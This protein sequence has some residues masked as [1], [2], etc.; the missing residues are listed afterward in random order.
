MGRLKSKKGYLLSLDIGTEFVKALIFKIEEDVL[1]DEKKRKGIVL[2]FSRQRQALGNMLAGAVADIDGVALT[3][4]SAIEEA[5]RMARV[6]PSRAVIGVAGEFIKGS[7][8]AFSYQRQDPEREID[9]S[10]L[11]NVVQKAQ[12]KAYDKM[13][14]QLA[15][16]IC[17]SEIEIR[18]VNS[19]IT[20][21]KIDGHPVTNPLGF[22]GG[23]IFLSTFS[24]YAPLVHL[25]ALESIAQKLKLDL[26][27]VSADS[28][29]LTKTSGFNPTAGAIFIDI[30]GGT[31]DV[32]LVRQNRMEGIKSFSLAGQTFTKCLSRNL[33]LGFNEAE[34]IKVR[35]GYG[36][37]GRNVKRKIN[38]ILK[39]DMEI[40]LNGVELILEDF[41]QAEYFPPA[42]LLCGGGSLLPGIKNILKKEAISRQ[43]WEKF[44]FSQSPQIGFIQPG[45][46]ENIIDQT[47]S[48]N[49]PEDVTPLAL[50]SL[51][52]E[53]ATEE[54]QTLPP[55][56]R[57]MARIMHK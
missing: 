21:I 49:G 23:E 46:V 32:A 10:E 41:S 2:G 22:E 28:Y 29:A 16:E 3:C 27:S 40:W 36:Q 25:K 17:Q 47:K 30:G 19:L 56:L 4:Q 5:G 9:L 6:K 15:S 43:W 34:E 13:R 42:I 33:G 57:R 11:Q 39:R 54:N 24:V 38:D 44:P 52:L 20:D 8:T 31:T 18:L 51:T 45:H 55:I 14:S 1:G 53:I 37:L 35:Y 12:W 26:L 7:T 48:L 50:A